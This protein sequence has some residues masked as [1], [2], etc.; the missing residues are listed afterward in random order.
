MSASTWETASDEHLGTPTVHYSQFWILYG[1]L[2][3]AE[4]VLT[5]AIWADFIAV[6]FK[7]SHDMSYEELV[8]A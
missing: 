8:F 1:K 7:A 2:Q 5:G 6:F 4:S 3:Q